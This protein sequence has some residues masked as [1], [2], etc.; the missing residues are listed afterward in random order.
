MKKGLKLALVMALFCLPVVS[1]AQSEDMVKNKALST[2]YKNEITI[3]S[4]EL[5]ALKAKVKANPGD[6][7]LNV[8]LEQKKVALKELK[9]KKKIVDGAIKTENASLKAAKAAEKAK[10]KAAKAAEKAQKLHA[11]ATPAQ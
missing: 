8:E 4:H 9:E 11:P 6:V 7:Q 10:I 5:K 1:N 2:Q 3:A